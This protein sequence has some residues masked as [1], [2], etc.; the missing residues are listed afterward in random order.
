MIIDVKN[1]RCKVV[2]A[3]D[4]EKTWLDQYLSFDDDKARFYQQKSWYKGD[5][6][7]HM[8]EA[9]TQTFAAG[10][11]D[12]IISEAAK[13]N[14]V[15]ELLDKRVKPVSGSPLA[16][17]DWLRDYQKEAI[18]AAS[19][20]E[21][22]IFQHVT[23]AGK[24]LGR[25][26]PVL[27]FD[28]RIKAVQDIQVGDQ[29][30]GPDS[31]PRKV[32]STTIG[33][34]ALFR[35]KPIKGRAWI[36]NSDHI[37]T[38][39]NIRNDRLV[40]ISVADYI[41]RSR[42]FKHVHKQFA[43]GVEFPKQDTQLTVDPYFLG[44]SLGNG[45]PKHYLTAQR[46]QRLQL[47]A[48]LLDTDGYYDNGSFEI[49]Q[50]SAVIAGDI[51]FLARSLGFRCLESIKHVAGYGDFHRLSI[52]GHTDRIPTRIPRKQAA[53]RRQIKD[54]LHTG[55]AVES[56][57]DGEY[58]GFTIDGDSRFLLGDFTVTHNTQVMVALT[59][60]HGNLKWLILTHKIDLVT[61]I[62]E[63]FKHVTGEEVGQIGEG[64]FKPA[65]VTVGTFQ[66]IHAML[67]SPAKK[68][69]ISKFLDTIDGICVDECHVCPST[70]FWKVAMAVPNAYYRYGFSATPF[71]RGDKKSVYVW[72]A[73]GP[74][75]HRVSAER[76]IDA[77]IL[78][79]P[80]I[81]M[82][83]VRHHAN[84]NDS[85]AKVESACI[86]NNKARN[87]LVCTAA[88]KTAKPCLLFV[89]N[90]DHGKN[91]EKDLRS[92]GEK[93]EFVWGKF[94]TE[95]RRAAIRRLVHGDVDILICSVIFQE[96][97]DIPELQSLVLGQGGKSVIGTLQR[98]GRGMR[99]TDATGKVMKSEF[100]IYDFADRGCGCKYPNKHKACRWL[101]N[102]T[103]ER[104]AAYG[105]EKYQ[106]TEEQ[107]I[108]IIGAKS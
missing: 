54:V 29:L 100:D 53:P 68:S 6:K 97:I 61:Q 81:H 90:V 27:M 67:Q 98:V 45:I 106:V 87:D 38:L 51:A 66:T 33:F 95:V 80:K 56:I 76:L 35:I 1:Q 57:G 22:G 34:G 63:R 11:L 41:T 43:V 58:F 78:A 79:K 25:D 92:R 32:L 69:Q 48:G 52:S 24:C 93:V 70:T 77:G 65:R 72:G 91:L 40:D 64:L 102:H 74:V 31:T 83:K 84:A 85:W 4:Q 89:K 39:K 108:P 42:G 99:K 14:I 23:G 28:G 46:E 10:F 12:K 47:L 30:M 26:T 7:I 44:A 3:T 36:C 8:L 82:I 73:L 49:V 86:V 103:K 37:L 5:G 2:S 101:E 75:I 104:I 9:V 15:V 60:N 96:G 71:S 94:N 59:S 17:T 13:A 50:K 62:K 105:K 55:F 19:A 21:R 16:K 20:K 107:L 88:M 18:E